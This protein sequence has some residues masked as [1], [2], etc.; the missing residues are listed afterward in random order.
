MDDLV[1]YSLWLLHD[2]GVVIIEP[3]TI[4]KLYL[5]IKISI[6]LIPSVILLIITLFNTGFVKT[7]H[8]LLFYLSAN[9]GRLFLK[10]KT[11]Y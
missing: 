6:I 7:K 2:V 3:S 5:I 4:Y 8:F 1:V 11:L 10:F 9:N